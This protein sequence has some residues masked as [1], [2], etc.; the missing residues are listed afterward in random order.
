[1]INLGLLAQN[2][3]D[4]NAP[5]AG[6]GL[7][8][9]VFKQMNPSENIAETVDI[10]GLGKVSFTVSNTSD[11]TTNSYKHNKRI[12][13]PLQ[14]SSKTATYQLVFYSQYESLPYSVEQTNGVTVIYFPI[15]MYPDLRQRLSE[16]TPAKKVQ[17][18]VE[19]RKD[20]YREAS[21]F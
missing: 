18:K 16:A 8:N 2:E 14:T 20:G 6:R 11:G 17:L 15:E 1:M 19:I 9:R 5:N 7:A 12:I 21:V 13:M 10:T 4:P 3:T